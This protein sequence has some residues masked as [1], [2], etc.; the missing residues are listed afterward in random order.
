MMFMSINKTKQKFFQKEDEKLF[1]L[2]LLWWCLSVFFIG[3]FVSVF[4]IP[5]DGVWLFD[6][7]SKI[8]PAI[9][10]WVLATSH[11][12]VAK[13]VWIYIVYTAPLITIYLTYAIKSIHAEKPI[14][15]VL[16]LLPVVYF[17]TCMVITGIFFGIDAT[18]EPPSGGGTWFQVYKR[19]V[20]GTILIPCFFG[21]IL[22]SCSACFL[23]T[24]V[25]KFKLRN[26]WEK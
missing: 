3:S 8:T 4:S 19:Y 18:V 9:N 11:K 7:I 2:F 26:Y 5:I 23:L 13:V 12:D 17:G 20:F 22:I 14:L 16:V 1:N 15:L 10:K 21:G 6:F 24:L 25:E